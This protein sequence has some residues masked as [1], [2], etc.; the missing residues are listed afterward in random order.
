MTE[1]GNTPTPENNPPNTQSYSSYGSQSGTSQNGGAYQQPYGAPTYGTPA[2][3]PQ[4]PG[5]KKPKNIVG[6]VALALSALGFVLGLFPV[7]ALFGWLLL[8]AGFITGIVGL[9]QKLKEKITSIIAIALSVVGTIASIIAI[10]VF[11]AN[12]IANDP[13]FAP[14]ESVTPIATETSANSEDGLNDRGNIEASVGDEIVVSGMIDDAEVYKFKVSNIDLNVQ[15]TEEYSQPSE[16]GQFIKIDV[17]VNSGSKEAFEENYYNE[18]YIH[19]SSFKYISAEGTTFNGN[20]GSVPSYMCIPQSEVLP[21]EIGPA[22]KASGSII[23]DVPATNG[24][25]IFDDPQTG[26]SVEY[27]L[28]Q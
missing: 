26:N 12:T 27:R 19:G 4:Q 6:I 22:Q 8:F 1:N 24:V 5:G 2:G 25:I 21:Q 16:N 9:F 23:L 14:M 28:S 20:L 17:E 15:C 11:A 3:D 10:V 7:T 18:V 13:Q